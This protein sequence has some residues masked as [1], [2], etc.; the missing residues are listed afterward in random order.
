MSKQAAVNNLPPVSEQVNR[1]ERKKARGFLKQAILLIP[2][3]LR[4]LYRLFKDP[5]APSTEK[6]LLIGTVLYAI[7]PLDLIPDFIPFIGEVDDL[8]LIA[9]VLLRLLSR[10]PGD[11]IRQHWEGGG[12]LAAIIEKTV[13]AAPY[14][15]PK[16]VRRILLGRVEIAPQVKSGG[17]FSS[18]ARPSEAEIDEDH[19]PFLQSNRQDTLNC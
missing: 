16:R 2:N 18:P 19:S 4:L 13:K 7:S 11:V 12:D 15:L 14:V 1:D 3:L 9:L 10:T 5:R 8:Y 6:A 17:L